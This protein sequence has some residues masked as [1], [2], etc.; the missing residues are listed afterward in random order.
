MAIKQTN[1]FPIDQQ[2][3]NAV[4]LAYPFSSFAISG[5]ATD[6]V[7]GGGKTPF[8]LNYT[9]KDQIKSN[10]TI[11]FTTNRGERPLNPNY[12]GGLKDIVFEQL[13]G[14][15]FEIV[16]KRIKD[17]LTSYFP[18]VKLKNLEVL[19]DIDNNTLKIVMSYTVFNNS[20]DT[21]ELNFNL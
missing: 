7:R 15:T 4:G 21:L 11:F 12:G 5:S 3:R 18:E 13:T 2:P 10:L 17:N 16:E 19:E 20:E 9:T 8:K 14:N 6:V 1:I